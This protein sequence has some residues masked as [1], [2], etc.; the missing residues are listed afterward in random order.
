MPSVQYGAR[1]ASCIAYTAKRGDILRPMTAHIVAKASRKPP[2][3]LRIGAKLRSALLLIANEGS[4]QAE[5]ARRAGIHP[6]NLC[7]ALKKPHVQNT[8]EAMK[9]E[10]IG[11]IEALK[12]VFKARALQHAHYLLTE[13][14][15]EAVQAR[16][17]EFLAGEARPGT[18]VNVQINNDRGGYEYARPGQQVVEIR[19]ADDQSSALDGQAPED[20]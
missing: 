12:G 11:D 19:G 3:K 7:K 20:Q 17:V 10:V 5:A 9:L 16:M 14:K 8:L 6:V 15:S 4:T 18:Q 13:A 2:A 1:Q